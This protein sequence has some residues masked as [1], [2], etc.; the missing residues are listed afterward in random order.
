VPMI[1]QLDEK[2]WRLWDIATLTLGS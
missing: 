1:T 2:R